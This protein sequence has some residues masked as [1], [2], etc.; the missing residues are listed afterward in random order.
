MINLRVRVR[1]RVLSLL[2][3]GVGQHDCSVRD[4]KLWKRFWV[5]H[6]HHVSV[7]L[8]FVFFILATGFSLDGVEVDKTSSYLIHLL[9]HLKGKIFPSLA[10]ETPTFS[11]KIHWICLGERNWSL[12]CEPASSGH[13]STAQWLQF[14]ILWLIN[15]SIFRASCMMIW[16]TCL[17]P[18]DENLASG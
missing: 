16:R 14:M 6:Q 2:A 5:Y 18:S 15:W 13:E 1:V 3:E 17:P 4:I 9:V 10:A 12:Y 8:F 11:G 7:F